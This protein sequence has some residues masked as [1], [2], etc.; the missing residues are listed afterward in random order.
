MWYGIYLNI[1]GKDFRGFVSDKHGHP[2]PLYSS[3]SNILIIVSFFIVIMTILGCYC[4]LK[5]NNDMV[6]SYF[7]LFI[8]FFVVF[9]IAAWCTQMKEVITIPPIDKYGSEEIWIPRNITVTE[10]WD[11]LQ[12][13][14]SI[15]SRIF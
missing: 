14:V 8:I 3:A 1:T 13:D 9:I 12:K 2:L 15:F 5:E 10:A 7:V 6:G 11:S 4:I